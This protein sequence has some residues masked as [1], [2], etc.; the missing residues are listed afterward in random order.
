MKR[1][2]IVKVTSLGDIVETLPVVSDLRRAFPS[3]KVDWAADAAFA[4]I[5][6]WNPG[7]DRVL[8]AP[9]RKFK[10]AR[11]WNDLKEIAGS[12]SELRAEKYD[13][14]VDIHGVYK[15]AIIAFIARGKRRFG[16][17]NQDLGERGAAFAYNARFGPRPHTDAWRGMRVSVAEALGYE[18]DETPDYN[19]RLPALARSLDIPRGAPI[20][21][22]FH[23]TSADVKKWPKE[24]WGEVGR[25]LVARGYSIALPWGTEG[26]RG[27]AQ[28]IAAL[29]P[30]AMVLPKLTVEECAHWIE[31]SQLV[32]GTDTGLVH[33]AHALQRRTVMLF[34][35]TSREHFGVNAPGRSVSVGDHGAPPDVPQVL[36]AIESVMGAP[37]HAVSGPAEAGAMVR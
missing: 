34:A 18:F 4:D 12:I 29:V 1:I 10:K 8:S 2:L 9:L 24:H 33:L 31:A 28:A 7:V 21:M 11:N 17:L 30:G 20:A 25:W 5:I 26:E 14:I 3:A 19:V 36:A 37:S 32:V 23:A 16:Y 13:V 6:R 27:E 15:S 22:L 35:A